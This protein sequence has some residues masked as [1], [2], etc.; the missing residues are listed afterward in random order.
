MVTGFHVFDSL[1][2][3][4]QKK[5]EKIIYCPCIKFLS[6]SYGSGF[7]KKKTFIMIL[8]LNKCKKHIFERIFN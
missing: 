6:I 2:I 1:N 8:L 3:T 5:I 7:F 4:K